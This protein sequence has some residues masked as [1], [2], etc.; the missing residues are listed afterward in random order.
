MVKLYKYSD[1]SP[2][3]DCLVRAQGIVMVRSEAGTNIKNGSLKSM[4]QK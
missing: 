3:S 2:Y 1:I 4:V